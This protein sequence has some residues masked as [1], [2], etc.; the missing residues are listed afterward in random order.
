MGAFAPIS[1]PVVQS[2][3]LFIFPSIKLL[4]SICIFSIARFAGDQSS[5]FW[6]SNK[7]ARIR[8]LTL[9]RMGYRQ[10]HVY[11]HL[12]FL[13]YKPVLIFY[14]NNVVVVDLQ[15]LNGK[16]GVGN[17]PTLLFCGHTR[18]RSI[19]MTMKFAGDGTTTP[20]EILVVFF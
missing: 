12:Q 6:F 14:E 15:L 4:N 7:K 1:S 10:I 16:N 20:Q 19:V 17:N 3:F 8:P 18:A 9:R 5:C 13:N 2:I 11:R